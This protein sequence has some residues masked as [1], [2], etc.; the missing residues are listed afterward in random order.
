MKTL[1]T[2]AKNAEEEIYT[3]LSTDNHIYRPWQLIDY[4]IDPVRLKV[5]ESEIVSYMQ[6]DAFVRPG[7]SVK[8]PDVSMPHLFLKIDGQYEG[9]EQKINEIKKIKP[10]KVL[11]IDNVLLVNKSPITSFFKNRPDWYDENNGIDIKNAMK[12][13]IST[14]MKLK[15]KYRE[16]Y[17]MA[18][19]RVIKSVKNGSILAKQPTIRVILETLIYNNSKVVEMY[20]DFDYQYMVPKFLVKITGK[21][22]LSTYAVLRMMLMSELGFDVIILDYNGYSSIENILS[23]KEFDFYTTRDVDMQRDIGNKPKKDKGF[24]LSKK[25]IFALIFIITVLLIMLGM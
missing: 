12:E 11:V 19:D 22:S 2:T 14:L 13:N 23:K 17:F 5:T 21:K 9:I 25:L 24:K 7:F 16:N 1:N 8:E 18:V 15:P 6:V 20:H 4:N 10:E 3:I